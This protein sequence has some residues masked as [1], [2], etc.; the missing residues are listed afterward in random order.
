MAKIKR[1]FLMVLDSMGCGYEPDADKFGDVGAN[2]LK[3]IRGSEKFHCPNMEKLGLFHIDGFEPDPAQDDY[4][5][6]AEGVYGRLQEISMGKDTTVGH[7]EIAGLISEKPLPTYPNGF[8]KE[9]I[10]EFEKRTGRKVICNLPYSGTEVIKDYGEEHLKTGALIVYT[11]ADSVFQIAANKSIVPLEDL[12]RYC[13]IAREML[14]GDHG[15]GRVIARPFVGTCAA[16]FQRT[17]E[18][19]DFSLVPPRDTMLD[20]LQKAGKA[21]IGIGKIKDIFAG[22][23]ID[24]CE[25]TT[26]TVSNADGLAK[27]DALLPVDFEGLCFVNLVETDMIY[28]HRR[29]IDGYANAITEFDKWLGEFEKKMNDDDIIMV[30][31]DHGCDPGFTGTDHTRE[32]IPFVAYGKALKKGAAL[33]TRQGFCDIAKTIL[34]IFD[35]DAPEIPGKSFKDEILA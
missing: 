27:T 25:Y 3:S 14:V 5:G 21:S 19:H 24:D 23:G 12:Y 26:P 32:Y 9:V 6:D 20:E 8:P 29:D 16:D 7:W 18:R 13:R 2:T 34:D 30:T 28:G 15:V 11:S 22:K 10:D 1:V 31:A 4:V 35:I 17:A 33:G